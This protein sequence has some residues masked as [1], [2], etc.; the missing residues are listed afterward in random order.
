MAWDGV[1]LEKNKNK[2]KKQKT[3]HLSFYSYS[4]ESFGTYGTKQ[5]NRA[6]L[7]ASFLLK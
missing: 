2:N 7:F 1:S 3:Q 6:H 4:K 5:A